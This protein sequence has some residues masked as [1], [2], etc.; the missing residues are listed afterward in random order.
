MEVEDRIFGVVLLPLPLQCAEKTFTILHFHIKRNQFAA[1]E[2][3]SRFSVRFKRPDHQVIMAVQVNLAVIYLTVAGIERRYENKIMEQ[4]L[5]EL[6]DTVR[7]CI[8][9]I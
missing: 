7:R 5:E 1:S 6:A 8:R 3:V 4:C 2:I 9:E